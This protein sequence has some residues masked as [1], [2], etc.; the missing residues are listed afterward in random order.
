MSQF[1]QNHMF[2]S[3]FRGLTRQQCWQFS[4]GKSLVILSLKIAIRQ[5][6][7]G[8]NSIHFLNLSTL[9]LFSIAMENDAFI[10]DVPIQM[11][12]FHGYVKKT[13]GKLSEQEPNAGVLSSVHDLQHLMKHLFP[14]ESVPQ[15]GVPPKNPWL[16]E[17][18][19]IIFH[20][21]SSSKQ[22]VKICKNRLFANPLFMADFSIRH[23]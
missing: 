17:I 15:H 21:T 22:G 1:I 16:S 20:F 5:Y 18:S 4:M 10:D 7:H 19:L 14:G 13:K 3:T 9:W 6:K 8:S 12:I 2:H 23:D 11:V